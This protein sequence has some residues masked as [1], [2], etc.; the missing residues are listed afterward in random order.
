MAKAP[1]SDAIMTPEKMKPLLALSKRE[2]VQAAIGLTAEGDAL[3]LLDKKAKPKK[4]MAMLRADAGKAKMQINAASLRFGRA[5]VDS[6]YDSGMVRFFINKEAP[7]NMRIKL[8]EVVKRIPYQKVELNVDPSLELEGEEDGAEGVPQPVEPEAPASEAPAA[9]PPPAPPPPPSFD[10]TALTAALAAL[11]GRIAKATGTDEARK[12]LLMRLAGVANAAIKGQDAAAAGHAIAELRTALDAPVAPP[13]A[14]PG[15]DLEALKH[16]LAGLIGRIPAAAGTDP[17]RRTT[18]AGLAGEANARLKAEDGIGATV[19]IG[20]LRA[21]VEAP[22]AAPVAPAAATA[23]PATPAA[24]EPAAHTAVADL[25]DRLVHLRDAATQLK[26]GPDFMHGLAA[27][28]QAVRAGAAGAAEM[29]D[30]LERELA[31]QAGNQRRDAAAAT[32]RAAAEGKRGGVV[33]FAKLRLSVSAAV[34]AYRSARANLAA[35]WQA[36]LLTEDFRDD[37]RS[38]DG[39]TE[40]LVAGVG[41]HVPDITPMAD[42]VNDALDA[43]SESTD[44][45]ARRGHADAARQAIAAY[46]QSLAG[47]EMLGFMETTAAGSFAIQSLLDTALKNLEAAIGGAGTEGATPEP[48]SPGVSS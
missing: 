7:G 30:A 3:I 29:V 15:P 34:S 36:L 13:P 41:A 31:E 1:A 27:A 33:A 45:A 20:R 46:R 38:S 4:V 6:D 43:M 2:P 26:L 10:A 24:P 42:A 32:I 21:A 12:A 37:P 23:P 35:A 8:V 19:A 17:A 14:P 11:I 18:L 28:V 16:E 40:Q 39:E 5:E 9:A 25:T 47:E 44:P 22:A 48:V